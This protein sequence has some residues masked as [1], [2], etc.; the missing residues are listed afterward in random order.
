MK[1]LTLA[2][3]ETTKNRPF[4]S[5]VSLACFQQHLKSKLNPKNQCKCIFS[6]FNQRKFIRWINVD[7]QK[8]TCGVTISGH[9]NH[10]RVEGNAKPVINKFDTLQTFYKRIS[11]EIRKVVKQ[12]EWN[13]TNGKRN[14]Q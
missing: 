5:C 11:F 4:V 12:L 6:A 14:G 3:P 2:I 8:L 10:K 9:A 13:P 1:W 7:I